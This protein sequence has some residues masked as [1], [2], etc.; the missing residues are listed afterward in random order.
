[1]IVFSYARHVGILNFTLQHI[2]QCPAYQQEHFDFINGACIHDNKLAIGSKD[3]HQLFRVEQFIMGEFP[4]KKMH[5]SIQI[6][7]LESFDFKA[8]TD[9]SELVHTHAKL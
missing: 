1:M 6:K 8:G 2:L 3:G 9:S 5:C 4:R 7:N